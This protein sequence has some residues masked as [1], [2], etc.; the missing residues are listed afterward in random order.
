MLW[1]LKSNKRNVPAL[2][3]WLDQLKFKKNIFFLLIMLMKTVFNSFMTGWLV[4]VKVN[5]LKKKNN[6][7]KNRKLCV[8][9]N[10]HPPL[11]LAPLLLLLLILWLL[12]IILNLKKIFFL[13]I[14]FFFI[15]FL[16][17]FGYFF[18]KLEFKIAFKAKSV[19]KIS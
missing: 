1:S 14:F 8:T 12:I 3:T 2:L 10:R 6:K 7:K 18:N 5:E 9:L 15:C 16:P 19:L 4:V 13:N 17:T 11:F